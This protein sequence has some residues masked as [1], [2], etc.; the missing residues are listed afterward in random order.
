M[1]NGLVRVLN[2]AVWRLVGSFRRL[3]KGPFAQHRARDVASA[4]GQGD[5]GL[6]A[7]LAF[8]TFAVLIGPQFPP[9]DRASPP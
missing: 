3:R 9:H 4:S 7:F 5:D 8:G 1:L 2:Q 6:V